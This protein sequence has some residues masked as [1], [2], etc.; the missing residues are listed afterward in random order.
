MTITPTSRRRFIEEYYTPA[1]FVV[2]GTLNI[3]NRVLFLY[4]CDAFTRAYYAKVVI[5]TIQ[6]KFIQYNIDII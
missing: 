1:D 3:F 6:H 4:A 2:G 5:Y